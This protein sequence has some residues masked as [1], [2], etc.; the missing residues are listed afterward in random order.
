MLR[1]S[2]AIVRHILGSKAKF[3]RTVIRLIMIYVS[4][5]YTINKLLIDTISGA[6]GI[7]R[8]IEK[9]RKYRTV[10]VDIRDK[11]GVTSIKD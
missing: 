1:E 4:K 3:Y 2:S 10:D 11:L 8:E 7:L 9:T 6:V 5:C